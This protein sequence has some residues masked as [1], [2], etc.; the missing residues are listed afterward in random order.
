MGFLAQG[1]RV[2]WDAECRD[3]ARYQEQ[4]RSW[5]PSSRSLPALR[6]PDCFKLN[7]SAHSIALRVTMAGNIA[8]VGLHPSLRFAGRTE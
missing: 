2:C 7:S 6:L 3:S 5:L 4:P 8:L 1:L